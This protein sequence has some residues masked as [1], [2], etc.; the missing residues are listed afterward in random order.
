MERDI[1][2]GK[3]QVEEVRRELILIENIVGNALPQHH[4]KTM[5]GKEVT[6]SSNHAISIGVPLFP[7]S[8][9]Y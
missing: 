7:P 6:F 2:K 4:P 9:L 5:A 8:R 1:E 3:R